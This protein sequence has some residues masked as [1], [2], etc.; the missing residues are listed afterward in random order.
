MHRHTITFS[1]LT[2]TILLAALAGGC[3]SGPMSAR[4]PGVYPVAAQ[5]AVNAENTEIKG[6]SALQA[7][8]NPTKFNTPAS[9]RQP[10]LAADAT[11][12]G[13]W[14][15]R[16]I[17]PGMER[18]THSLPSTINFS[19]RTHVKTQS[20]EAQ[21][22]DAI[23]GLTQVT[24]ASDGA[25]F[26]P[27]VSRDGQTI[28]FASTQH[29]PTADLYMAKVGSRAITQLTNDAG[30]DVMPAL[31][32]D[33]KRVA[34]SSDRG[35]SW[36]IYVMPASGGRAVQITSEGNGDALHPTWSPDGSRLAF[37][38]LGAVSGRWELW[39]AQVSNPAS[40]EFIGYGM[41]PDWCPTAGT[42]EGGTDRIAFQ[43][44]RERGDRAFG[45]WT[46][47]YKPGNVGNPVEIVSGSG[48]AAINP[49]WSVDGQ[50]IA[51][52]MAPIDQSGNAPAD[53]WVVA[54]DGAA[55][56]NVTSGTG[57]NGSPTWGRDGKLFFVSNRSGR[58]QLWSVSSEKALAAMPSRNASGMAAKAS[59]NDQ[60]AN[61]APADA[62]PAPEPMTTEPTASVPTP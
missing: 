11:N 38:R 53:I 22:G 56:V 24:F 48:A 15:S 39:V 13:A 21:G 62:T 45:L 16:V 6:D 5:P 12:A 47:D 33:N 31:S 36:Q 30:N 1:A 58:E 19:A 10:E 57:V 44:G 50:F 51:Y 61:A 34:F 54:G 26:D 60:T 43:R 55:R 18:G 29:R 3:S 7:T 40:A 20:T 59:A 49:S 4:E 52:T 8:L 35:G 28:V 41:F 37:C 17:V 9:V 46:V 2:A 23:E 42:G 25:D 14:F 32:P 27:S